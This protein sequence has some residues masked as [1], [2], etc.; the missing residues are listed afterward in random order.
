[1]MFAAAFVYGLMVGMLAAFVLMA[2][3]R[4]WRQIRE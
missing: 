3:I 2:A 4:L 1:M